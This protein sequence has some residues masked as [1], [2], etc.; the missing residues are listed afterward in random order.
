MGSVEPDASGQAGCGAPPKKESSDRSGSKEK[1][2][3]Q[4][5]LQRFF[6]RVSTH[7]MS[8]GY[9]LQRRK[10]RYHRWEWWQRGEW[11]NWR[12]GRDRRRR[13]AVW[14]VQD[15]KSTR[16][17][18]SHEWISYAVFCLKKKKTNKTTKTHKPT[19]ENKYQ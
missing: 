15:R 13:N 17:N 6:C 2:S 11:R 5:R 1:E 9:S 18:S 16:L 8:S 12:R 10:R 19:I 3:D 14:P 4:S 7:C